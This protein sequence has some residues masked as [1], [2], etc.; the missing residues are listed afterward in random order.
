M[1]SSQEFDLQAFF[2]AMDARRRDQH[3]THLQHL[4]CV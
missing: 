3:L 1:D 4:P 2:D